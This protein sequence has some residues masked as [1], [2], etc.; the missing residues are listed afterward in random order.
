MDGHMNEWMGEWRDEWMGTLAL[1]TFLIP[2]RYVYPAFCSFQAVE[3]LKGFEKKD[4]KVQS[5]AATNLSFLYFLVSAL[6]VSKPYLIR[7]DSAL[8]LKH[9]HSSNPASSPGLLQLTAFPL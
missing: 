5:I 8:G 7:Q 6:C 4:S 1:H 2:S 3:T 9:L